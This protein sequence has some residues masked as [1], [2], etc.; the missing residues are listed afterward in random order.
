MAILAADRN[1][2]AHAGKT[3]A[4]RAG[5]PEL[6]EHPRARGENWTWIPQK[7][8]A[9]GTSPRTRG[10]LVAFT[11]PIP[12]LRNIPAHAGKTSVSSAKPPATG[13]HPRARGENPRCCRR[14]ANRSGT[15][16]R[17]R[18]KLLHHPN[19]PQQARNIPAH[20][21]KTAVTFRGAKPKAG[22]SPRTR[23]KRHEDFRRSGILRNI[24]AHAGKTCSHR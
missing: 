23:G 17:T 7:P 10:K 5:V 8:G 20:A 19:G 14:G 9:R 4:Y 22:T 6:T 21:G 2:P 13:E 3:A 11:H 1:I 12:G 15:S 18:G 24:P 16:P